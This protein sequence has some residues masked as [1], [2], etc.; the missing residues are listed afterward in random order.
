MRHTEDGFTI[1]ELLIATAVFTVIL[2]ITAAALIG[3]S[4]TYVKGSVE[5]NTQQTARKILSSISQDIQFNNNSSIILNPSSSSNTDEFYFCIGSDV[6]VYNLNKRLTSNPQ[7]AQDS[8]WVLIRYT[9]PICPK[10]PP[11][12]PPSSNDSRYEELMASG[13]RLGQLSISENSINNNP[14]YTISIEIGY[15]ANNVLNG[16]DTPPVNQINENTKYNYRCQTGLDSSFCAV[17]SLTTTVAPRI[18]SE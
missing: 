7:S 13:Q 3:I 4:Q 2:I 10:S 16:T 17:S 6:Y 11:S 12:M 1:I 5:G 9:N 14:A 8:T 15:G 18:N